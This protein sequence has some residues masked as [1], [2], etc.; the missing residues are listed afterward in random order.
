MRTNLVYGRVINWSTVALV[1]QFI[2]AHLS[3]FWNLR[4]F[5]LKFNAQLGFDFLDGC[6]LVNIQG[7]GSPKGVICVVDLL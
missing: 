3:K 4:S 6:E 5:A 1:D 2:S 7:G